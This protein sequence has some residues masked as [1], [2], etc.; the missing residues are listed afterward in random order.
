MNSRRE[1]SIIVLDS[2]GDLIGPI[3]ELAVVKDRLVLIEPDP[4]FPLALNPL[5]IPR[6]NINHVISLL[7]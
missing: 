3:K 4:D 7:E 5:D 6:A 2:K 1:P